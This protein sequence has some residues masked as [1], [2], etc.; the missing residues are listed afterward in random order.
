[1]GKE[2]QK[3]AEE[4]SDDDDGS[5]RNAL[6]ATDSA[7]SCGPAATL[8][9]WPLLR[10]CPLANPERQGSS[11]SLSVCIISVKK[12]SFAPSPARAH[13]HTHPVEPPLPV[14]VD[15][16]CAD[17]LESIPAGSTGIR[18]S[19]SLLSTSHQSCSADRAQG[20]KA[21]IHTRPPSCFF[22][23]VGHGA[24]I[25]AFF[26]TRNRLPLGRR[27]VR[28]CCECFAVFT[29]LLKRRLARLGLG[30]NLLFPRRTVI[31]DIEE[32]RGSQ[33]RRRR[34][35]KS[36]TYNFCTALLLRKR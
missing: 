30:K 11:S 19:F 22:S 36:S 6:S 32:G 4:K 33:R 35:K 2:Q 10:G 27:N 23:G 31:G 17:V 7:A 16:P 26:P 29:T 24:R 14:D 8:P 21:N 34:M 5:K 28:R 9:P 1:M 20:R 25:F 13:T 15:D 3:K 18:V 12:S